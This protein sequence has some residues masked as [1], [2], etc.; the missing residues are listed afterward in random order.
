MPNGEYAIRWVSS[1]QC[2]TRKID[3]DLDLIQWCLD[4]Y[5]SSLDGPVPEAVCAKPCG[6][7][8]F[9]IQGELDCCWQCR[10]CRSNEVVQ[11]DQ[12]G[13]ITCPEFSWPDQVN[14]TT[15]ILIDPT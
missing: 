13:C 2:K 3:V 10:K 8:E 11:E 6:T 1:W 15:C 4:G 9:Y 5:N 14:F 12:Q 7:E